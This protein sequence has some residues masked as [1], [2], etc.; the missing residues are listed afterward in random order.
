MLHP[1]A[2]TQIKFYKPPSSISFSIARCSVVVVDTRLSNHEVLGSS[3]ILD[4]YNK[5]IAPNMN[6]ILGDEVKDRVKK[7]NFE[8]YKIIVM[9]MIGEKKGQGIMVSSRCSW[10][11]SVDN[12]VSH[13]FQNKHLFCTCSVY[14]VY[15]E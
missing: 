2:S 12:Y 8:R 5:R 6:R 4:R 14:G 11:D 7:L 3:P 10:D 15:Q 1:S 9:V 13:T